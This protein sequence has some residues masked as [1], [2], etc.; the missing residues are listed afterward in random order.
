MRIARFDTV[1]LSGEKNPNEVENLKRREG[2]SMTTRLGS[3][4]QCVISRTV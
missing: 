4:A 3:G 1:L 2:A